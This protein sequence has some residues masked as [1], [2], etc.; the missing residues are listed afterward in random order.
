MEVF[1]CGFSHESHSF[2]GRLT[3]VADFVGAQPGSIDAQPDLIDSR[4]IE[5][6]ILCAARDYGWNLTFPFFAQAIPSGPVTTEAFEIIAGRLMEG[7]ANAGRVDGIFL[8]LHGSMFVVDY[9]DSEGEIIKRVRAFVGAD[10]PI[11]V[12]LDLHANVSDLMAESADILTSYRTT[13]HT[14]HWETAHRA[15]TLLDRTMRQEIRPHSHVSRLP[16]MA[17]L[18][19]GRTIDPSGPMRSLMA[20]A[21]DIERND[22][23]ILD[24]SLNAGFYYGDVRDAGPSVIV[25]GDGQDAGQTEVAERLMREAWATRDYVSIT[26]LPVPEA[27]DKAITAAAEPRDGPI[28]LADYTDGMM[29]GAYGDG[30]ELL[31]ELLRRDPL[32]T[33]VGPVFDPVSVSEA[34]AAGEGSTVTLD[35]GGRHDASY[36]GGPIRVMAEVLSRT[37]GRYRRKGPYATGTNGD[38]GNSVLVRAGNV[39]ILLV[40]LAC[41]PEDREQYR[42]VGI[43]PENVAIIAMKGINHFRADFEPIAHEIIFVDSGGLISVDFTRFPFRNVRRPIWPLDDGVEA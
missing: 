9:P 6:G 33:V 20:V 7:L 27:V 12:L 34:V 1:A 19:M 31:A 32:G 4:S 37:D 5:G 42:L 14:D 41:Q 3:T 21:R 39:S 10:V 26:H 13:P 38:M 25:V 43:D 28:I 35:I 30:T 17:G 15:A 36:G 18:D 11:A 22:S 24:I 8:P 23:R 40:S 2:S 29:G 16:M